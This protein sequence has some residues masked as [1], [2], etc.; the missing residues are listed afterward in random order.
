MYVLLNF[1]SF[2]KKIFFIFFYFFSSTVGANKVSDL[3]SLTVIFPTSNTRGSISMHSNSLY[4][5]QLCKDI[6]YLY[7]MPLNRFLTKKG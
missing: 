2:G 6:T 1:S 4:Y 7:T 5:I 3:Y